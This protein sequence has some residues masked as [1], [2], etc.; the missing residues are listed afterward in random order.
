MAVKPINGAFSVAERFAIDFARL[1]PDGRLFT[2]DPTQLASYSGYGADVVS[3]TRG[4]GVRTKDGLV[5]NVPVG[6]LPPITLDNVGGNY[7]VVDIGGGHFA[8]FAHLQPGSL[9]VQVG[10]RVRAGQVLG[11]LGNSGNSDFPHLH[12]HVMNGPSP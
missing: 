5:D 9:T 12:F 10:N 3:V 2:G 8:F 1:A 11:R 6:S 7:V 4:V